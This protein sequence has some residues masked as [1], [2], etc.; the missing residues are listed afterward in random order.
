VKKML[1]W[2]GSRRGKG[3]ILGEGRH[4]WWRLQPNGQHCSKARRK[5]TF[6]GA[7]TNGNGSVT[8]ALHL[9]G[10]ILM[11]IKLMYPIIHKIQILWT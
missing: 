8:S 2:L 5:S 3:C 6:K 1:H 7:S 10:S 11:G 4:R 9:K